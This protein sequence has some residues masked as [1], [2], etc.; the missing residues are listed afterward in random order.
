MFN[1]LHCDPPSP[2][3]QEDPIAVRRFCADGM[4]A[5]FISKEA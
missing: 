2:R 3:A 4:S 5:V 1:A